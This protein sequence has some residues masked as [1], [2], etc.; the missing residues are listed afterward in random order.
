MFYRRQQ[1]D[2]LPYQRNFRVPLAGEGHLLIATTRLVVAV[3]HFSDAHGDPDYTIR[4]AVEDN[5]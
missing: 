3:H 1:P 4:V 5:P 2:P